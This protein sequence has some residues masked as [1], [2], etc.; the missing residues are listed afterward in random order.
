MRNNGSDTVKSFRLRLD[1]ENDTIID[2][3]HQ[4]LLAPGAS[5]Q[6]RT[7]IW[8]PK[9]SKR[10]RLSAWCDSINENNPDEY[11]VNDTAKT[12]TAYMVNPP[13]K[14]VLIEQFTSTNCGECPRG[15]TAIDTALSVNP[16]ALHIAYH[17][18]DSLALNR[19]DTLS[20]SFATSAGAIMVDRGYYSNISS[21]L[22]FTLPRNSAFLE[23]KPLIDALQISKSAPTPAEVNINT[24]FHNPSRTLTC[25]ITSTFEAEVS[26]DF[27]V[28]AMI[29]QDSIIGGLELDQANTMSGDSTIP[30]WGNQPQKISNFQHKHVARMFL[31]EAGLFGVP[32][33]VASDTQIG[34]KY[35]CTFTTVLPADMNIQT[36]T[37]I[38]FLYE[39][40]PDPLF[41]RILNAAS[42]PIKSVITNVQESITG[43]DFALFPQPA[44]DFVTFQVHIPSGNSRIE[45]YSL[46]GD[47]VFGEDIQHS[48][49]GQC[50]GSI[51][52]SAFPSGI[53]S[54]RIK[55]GEYAQAQVL[56]VLR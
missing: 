28:N 33:S 3:I 17:L 14:N 15:I 7:A 32:D 1:I 52:V 25:T 6:L 18:D 34:K 44:N 4:T 50:I 30:I 53:Y 38:G 47:L 45:V 42:I 54:F 2:S 9:Q 20:A 29:V 5:L 40:N 26:G 21:T 12:I 49:E 37:A 19:A 31:D 11:S 55:H 48:G 23:G 8:S 56:R 24:V 22:G 39:Y 16:G 46:L 13:K 36:V 43:S 41:G 35:A 27:R 51:D 10:Y